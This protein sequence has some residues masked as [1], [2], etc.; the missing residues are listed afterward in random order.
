MFVLVRYMNLVPSRSPMGS[1]K[2]ICF[3]VGFCL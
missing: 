2:R 1:S 3:T